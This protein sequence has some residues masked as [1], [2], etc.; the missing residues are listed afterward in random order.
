[1]SQLY[2]R[3]FLQILDSSLAEDYQTRHVFED[4]LKLVNRD[5]VCDMTRTAIARRTN[6]PLEVVEAAIAKLE[7]PDPHSRDSDHE[8]RRLVRLDD[9][10]DWGWRVVNWLRY[11]SIRTS[12]EQR[13]H[14]AQR[15][16]RYRVG[17]KASTS[18]TPP[19]SQPQKQKQP[20][21][22][23]QSIAY[24][25]P[26][27]SLQVCNTSTPCGADAPPCSTEL[28]LP[29][30]NPEPIQGSAGHLPLP[31]PAPTVKAARIER[32][33]AAEALLEWLNTAAGRS[34]AAVDANLRP[35][36]DRLA[37]CHDD[38]A[39]VRVMISRQCAIWKADS[40]MATYLRP[41][42]L[43]GKL[44]FRGYYDDRNQPIP[45]AAVHSGNGVR[46][47]RNDFIG[48]PES[49]AAW[50][51]QCA[52]ADEHFVEGFGP[53]TGRVAPQSQSNGGGL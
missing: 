16:A 1:M 45:S 9:H 48:T 32:R 50:A 7:S 47:H 11:D 51:A 35:I 10:R 41:A 26:T 14:N 46:P 12:V 44:K 40:V 28:P 39:G 31:S 19:S 38:V 43:F 6:V 27:C 36:T 24:I 34:F 20:Q 2:A 18:P 17:K 53:G 8:G 22:Q 33:E 4:I 23:I 30:M 29:L 3:V 5:G 37:D 52:A 21:I 42:T 13:E 15:M 25:E 49:R